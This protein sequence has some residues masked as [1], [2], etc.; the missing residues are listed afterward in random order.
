M[1]KFIFALILFFAFS[2]T[3]HKEK[4][5]FFLV[6]F[7]VEDITPDNP[8]P[9]TGYAGRKEVYDSIE[10][11]I[12]AKAMVMGEDKEYPKALITLDLIGFP[13]SL[14]D[15]LAS[16]LSTE[17]K[18]E[19]KQI[20]LMATHTHTAPETGVLLNINGNLLTGEQLYRIKKFRD[21]LLNQLERLVKTA[22][23]NREP[24]EIL[25]GK[26]EASFATN[27]RIVRN[28]KWEGFGKNPT[29]P[30]EHDLP[31]L[32]A[33]NQKKTV[34]GFFLN[35]ACHGTTLVREDNY[36]H[37]DWMGTAQKL[38]QERFPNALAMV[39]IGCGADSD[40]QP[41]GKLE[42]A[43]QHGK[44][45]ANE[46]EKIFKEGKAINLNNL[47]QTAFEKI[48]LDFDPE[49][50]DDVLLERSSNP[51]AT[52]LYSR[53]LLEKR[54][55]G[56]LEK[57]NYHYPIQIWKFGADMTMVFL[58]GEV[59]VDYAKRLKKELPNSNLWIN[60]YSNDV[61]CYVASQRLYHE[62]GYEV[63]ASMFYYNKPCRFQE[64]TEERIIGQVKT[65]V[66]TLSN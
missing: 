54:A 3:F 66:Y 38:L 36:V 46:V 20:A 37:G 35:Y 60:A 49:P 65:M 63:D 16:R 40:P 50:S 41:R 8:L 1:N 57:E 28:G 27:R 33:V 61:T 39:A 34:K 22:L 23:S 64:N 47:P 43:E 48:R 13:A 2:F 32:I 44:T 25:Y 24:C 11:H 7:A 4:K 52:G 55:R 62:G 6:G 12:F 21:E 5:K 59:V 9:L 26:G 10:Q 15:D 18:W 31:V 19:R 45:I 14:A 29:G 51:N 17:L 53:N 30:V 58:G 42:F 56:N